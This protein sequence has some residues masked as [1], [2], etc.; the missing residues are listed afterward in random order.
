VKPASSRKPACMGATELWRREATLARISAPKL[1]PTSSRQPAWS[2]SRRRNWCK[3]DFLSKAGLHGRDLG[4]ETGAWSLP[5][6]GHVQPHW[7]GSRR[8]KWCRPTSSRKPAWSGHVEPRGRRISTPKKG[9]GRLSCESRPSKPRQ[10]PTLP[11]G[12][13]CSTI[14]PGEL[15]FRVRD[16]NGCDLSGIT[17]RKKST[18]CEDAR[19]AERRYGGC[20][21]FSSESRWYVTPRA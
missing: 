10:R 8:R 20:R 5:I 11:Q 7:R 17:A 9:E 15:N 14:G 18:K 1:R 19:Y 21:A 6:P 12:C 3:A 2:R 16:G 13:P 4:A